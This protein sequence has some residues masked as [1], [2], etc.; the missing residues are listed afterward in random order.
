MQRRD[1]W[2]AISIIII[3]T[4]NLHFSLSSALA[5]AAD[6]H[7][8]HTQRSGMINYTSHM[9]NELFHL[10]FEPIKAMRV[11]VGDGKKKD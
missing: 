11:H 5:A 9:G 3:I 4:V 7:T 8:S 1:S 6:A 10:V 2:F